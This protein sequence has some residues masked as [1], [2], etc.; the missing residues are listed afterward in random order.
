M[1]ASEFSTAQSSSSLSH[2]V[3]AETL[4]QLKNK[5][6]FPLSLVIHWHQH[7]CLYRRRFS[8]ET[9][10]LVDLSAPWP[11][12]RMPNPGQPEERLLKLASEAA[13][14]AGQPKTFS[15]G[16]AHSSAARRCVP[17]VSSAMCI[18]KR[19][20][21]RSQDKGQLRNANSEQVFKWVNHHAVRAPVF[22]LEE[23]EGVTKWGFVSGCMAGLRHRHD[24]LP[25]SKESQIRALEKGR[26]Q[27]SSS[28]EL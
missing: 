28:L 17:L 6:L 24:S 1:G 11:T 14:V 15:T 26:H 4:S 25:K 22:D 7:R 19:S 27:H 8:G 23:P 20:A 9:T 2:E 13:A 10:T 12:F 16:I 21:I 18:N 5:D 3:R